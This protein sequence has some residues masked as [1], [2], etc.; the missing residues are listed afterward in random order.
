MGLTKPLKMLVMTFAR[1]FSYQSLSEKGNIQHHKSRWV[2]EVIY[3][4]QEAV[5]KLIFAPA[6]IP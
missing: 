3:V 5:V 6:I 1:Q 4:E 2:S